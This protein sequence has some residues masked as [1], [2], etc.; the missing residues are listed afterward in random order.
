[1]RKTLP[2]STKQNVTPNKTF[3]TLNHPYTM[4]IA[5]IK[6]KS[7]KKNS[8]TPNHKSSTTEESYQIKNPGASSNF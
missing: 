6:K 7:Q 2:P 1:M 8:T 5:L 4:K 3:R